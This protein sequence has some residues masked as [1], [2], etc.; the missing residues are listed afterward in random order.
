MLSILVLASALAVPAASPPPAPASYELAVKGAGSRGSLVFTADEVAFEAADP[1]KSRHW[2]YREL[3]QVRV[4]S[5]REIAF[6]TFEDRGRW[7]LGADRTVAFDLVEGTIDGRLVAL[8]LENIRR[9]VASSVLPAGLGE[10]TI[11]LAAKHHRGRQGTHGTIAI[12]PSGLAYET[13][14]RR[15]SRY[16]RFADIESI[17]RTSPDRLLVDAYEHGS[18]RPFSFQLKDPLPAAVFDEVWRR[19]NEPAERSRGGR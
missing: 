11:R 14:A 7:W 2:L 18:V 4:I 3:K 19:V 17:L 1:K 16:W 8:L 12:Y 15:G 5:L 9:P 6:D 13:D 10:S